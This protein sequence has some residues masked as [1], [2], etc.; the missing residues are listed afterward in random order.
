MP[1]YQVIIKET[2][3][4]QIKKLPIEYLPRI[5]RAILQLEQVPR[6][7]GCK[8]LVGSKNIYRIRIGIYRVV[9]EIIDKQLI[10][11]VFDVEHRKDVYK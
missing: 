4:K 8:K 7:A 1:T 2:A 9:Y 3:Q 10:V 11:Y 6:P 5:R